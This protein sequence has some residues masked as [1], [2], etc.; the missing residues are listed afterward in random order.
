MSFEVSVI[1]LSY[2]HEKYISFAIESILKQRF[3]KQFEII[4]LDDFSTDNT[5]KILNQFES[6]F[7]KKIECYK[8]SKN[9]G[10]ARNFEKA[11]LLAKGKY[12]SY[13]EGDDYWTDPLK[14]QKQFNF[15]EEHPRFVLAFHDFIT[16]DKGNNI[17]SSQN[18]LNK[19][20]QKNRTRKE[21]VTGC[22]IHQ[23]TMMFRNVVRKFPLGFFL[24]KNH[25]TFFIAYLSNW[26]EAGYVQCAPMHYRIHNESLWS[27]LSG[28]R[29]QLNGLATYSI[30]LFNVSPKYFGSILW[31]IGSKNKSIFKS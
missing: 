25:D 30:I 2:N 6:N 31:K 28:R 12:I 1:L 10:L 8:N 17:L 19:N 11:I 29:K 26:G 14:L 16:I 21:M 3:N 24:A 4:I 27:S 7:P 13:L 20:L 5:F 22:L 23:N 18:L 9:L 15:L